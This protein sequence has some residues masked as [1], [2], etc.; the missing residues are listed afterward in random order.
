MFYISASLFQRVLSFTSKMG[1]KADD[2]LKKAN[3]DKSILNN[4]DEKIPLEIYYS[5]LDAAIEI[6]G[7]NFFGLHMGQSA[8]PGDISILG[9]IMASCRNV[10]EALEKIGKYFAIIG[11]TQRLSLKVEKD[12][13]R[14]IWEMIKYFPNKCIKHC[15]ELGLSNTYNML[16]NIADK[17]VDI[18]E[19]WIKV[20]PPD[21]MSEYNKIFKCPILFNQPVA[22]LVFPSSALDIPLKHPNPVLLSLLEHHANS[23][24]SKIDEEDHFSRKISLRFFESIQGNNPTI[25][26]MAKDLGMSKRVLQNKL[27]EEGVTFSE[28][29]NSVRQELA[30]SYLAEKRYTIDDITYLVGFSEPSVFRRAFKRWTGM[31]ASQYRSSSEANFKS[32]ASRS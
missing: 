21:D 17:P 13:T 7:D 4:K 12:D 31:T 24:L 6:T 5:I 9:Y 14:L 29:A 11:S 18:K 15:I 22:A 23:F 20:G 1:I 10:R 28:L 32:Q 3:V 8:D 30:K 25:E 19:V 2:L 27:K 26:Q 16:Q